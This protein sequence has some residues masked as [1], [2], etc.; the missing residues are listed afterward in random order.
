MRRQNRLFCYKRK[1]DQK[2]EAFLRKFCLVSSL[3]LLVGGVF[4]SIQ[5]TLVFSKVSFLEKEEKKLFQEKSLLEEELFKHNSLTNAIFL[6][7]GKGFTSEFKLVYL[8][9]EKPVAKLP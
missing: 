5:L 4:W 1:T 7:Q 3:I 8:S 9:D 6:A 2:G